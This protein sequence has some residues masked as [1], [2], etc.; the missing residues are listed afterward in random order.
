MG[1]MDDDFKRQSI[2]TFNN[3]I[4]ELYNNSNPKEHGIMG[5]FIKLVPYIN[6]YNNTLCT[7]IECTDTKEI[8][9]LNK[10]EIANIL[11]PNNTYGY[12]LLDKLMNIFIKGEPAMGLFI[13]MGQ[14]QYRINPR[15]FYR[16]NDYRNL[17]DLINSFDITKQ[18]VI[19]K[20]KLK[21][22]AKGG[23]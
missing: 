22:M 20:Q 13:S 1:G 4:K 3:A 5:Q 15:L 8:I 16:G 11:E 21:K 9:P 14:Y 12:T 19:R 6:I 17:Q 18:Q 10:S 7:D 23:N 2:R